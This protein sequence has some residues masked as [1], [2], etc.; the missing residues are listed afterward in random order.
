MGTHDDG[1]EVGLPAG[2]VGIR[3][4]ALIGL[5]G[6]VAVVR[7]LPRGEN[8]PEYVAR[9]KNMLA[10]DPRTISVPSTSAIRSFADAVHE[11]IEDEHHDSAHGPAHRRVLRQERGLGRARRSSHTA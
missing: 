1:D 10:D 6:F 7:Y 3:D 8:V 9:R 2:A 11:M 5:E 4:R